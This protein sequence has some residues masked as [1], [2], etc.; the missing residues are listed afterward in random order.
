MS[1]KKKPEWFKG[2]VARVAVLT[3][4]AKLVMAKGNSGLSRDNITMPAPP[5]TNAWSSALR[6]R[7]G[8]ASLGGG[9]EAK[10]SA[11]RVSFRRRSGSFNTYF[12]RVVR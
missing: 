9:R 6:V 10:P 3:P 12:V 4:Y 7:E 1:R 2:L 8:R 11:L 5:R